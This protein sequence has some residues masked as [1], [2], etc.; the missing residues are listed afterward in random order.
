MLV[1]AEHVRDMQKELD[2]LI[3]VGVIHLTNLLKNSENAVSNKDPDDENDFQVR[4]V[5]RYIVLLRAMWSVELA[6]MDTHY[7]LVVR[8]RPSYP[9]SNS[10]GLQMVSS[11][12][13]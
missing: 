6:L 8:G 3:Q 1:D 5:Y 4:F 11:F 10:V 9:I 12:T 13:T 2:A 7:N